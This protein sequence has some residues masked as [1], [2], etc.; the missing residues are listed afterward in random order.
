M[1]GSAKTSTSTSGVTIPPEVLARY[2]SVNATAQNVAQTPFQQYSTNPNAF[3]APLTPTQN[4]GVANTNAAVGMAQ[5]YYNAATGFALAGS[6]PVN[7][8]PLDTGQYMNPYLN[9]VLGSTAAQIN[10]N[11]QQAQSG[12]T[13]TAMSQGYFGGD[14]SGIASAVLQG[15]QNL[16]AGQV[17]SGI[18]SDAY[19]QAMAAAQQ[20]QGV[21]LGAAQ[22]N[23]AATQQ[24]GETL[25]GLG[26][27]AQ[28]T[29]LA[30]AQAQ[31]GAGQVEQQTT[32]AGDT[33]LYN[34]FLQ[35]QS[36]PFQTAQFLANIAEGT[37]ALSGS[38]TTTQQPQSI[39]SDERLKEDMQPVGKGF[40]GANIYRFRYKG[41][42][43]TRLGFSAQETE[44]KH[45]EAV[46]EHGGFK[47]VDYGAAT[48][49]AARRGFALAANDNG[50]DDEE[51]RQ[52]R[53]AGGMSQW[54]SYPTGTNPMVIA[55][56]LAAQ[57][58]SYAPFSQAGL[59]GGQG[60]GGGPYGGVQGHVPA[61]SLPVGQLMV[62]HPVA[63]PQQGGLSDDLHSVASLADDAEGIKSDAHLAHQ[64]YDWLTHLGQPGGQGA[65]TGP[66]GEASGGLVEGDDMG[67]R[68]IAR[69]GR[70]P[71]GLTFYDPAHPSAA[72]AAELARERY[73]RSPQGIAANRAALAQQAAQQHAAALAAAKHP[74]QMGG[75]GVAPAPGNL[76]FGG[77]NPN[78][79]RWGT[80]GDLAHWAGQQNW[81]GPPGTV[82]DLGRRIFAAPLPGQS[83]PPATA[84]HAPLV[85]TPAPHAVA[86]PP[87]APPGAPRPVPAGSLHP[88]TPVHVAGPPLTMPAALP[89][90]IQGTRTPAV[91]INVG[92]VSHLQGGFAPANLQP[93]HE[94]IFHRV[95]DWLGGHFG[96]TG[97]REAYDARGIDPNLGSAQ[98]R[99][100]AGPDQGAAYDS[101][102]IDP[103][104]GSAQ[105]RA[106]AMAPPVQS[107]AFQTVQPLSQAVTHPDLAAAA[108]VPARD[109]R[110]VDLADAVPVDPQ[111]AARG[112]F[113]RARRR[114]RQ[115]GGDLSDPHNDDPYRPQGPG[116]N[117]PTSQTQTPK[118]AV[119][120]AP[121]QSGG[122]L[123]SALGDAASVASIA[124]FAL[125][126][127]GVPVKTG[128]RIGRDDGGLVPLVD[129]DAAS[130]KPG[131]HDPTATPVAAAAD[132]DTAPVPD[133]APAPAPKQPG[134]GAAAQPQ[135]GG[136]GGFLP[137]LFHGVEN[138]GKGLASA[139]GYQG[140]GHWDRDRLMPLLSAIG[141]AG[142]APTVHPFVALAAGLGGYGK[143]YMQQQQNEAQIGEEQANAGLTR[144]Q[145]LPTAL[146]QG[147][148]QQEG[149]AI[150]PRTNQIDWSRTITVPGKGYMHWGSAADLAKSVVGGGGGAAAPGLAT[151]QSQQGG[152]GGA[153]APAAAG[154]VRANYSGAKPSYVV[155]PSQAERNRA[156]QQYGIDPDGESYSNQIAAGFHS[157]PNEAQR[158]AATADAQAMQ[159]SPNAVATNQATLRDSLDQ[160]IK[161]PT[162]GPG[163][164]GPGQEARQNALQVYN[165]IAKVFGLPGDPNIDANSSE[166][167]ILNKLNTMS[168]DQLTQKYGLRAAST[169]AALTSALASG[170]IQKGAAFNI[171][172]QM[173][174]QN[175]QDR[176]FGE[177]RSNYQKLGVGDWQV[178]QAFQRDMGGLYDKERTVLPMMF[179][180]D[181]SGQSLYGRLRAHPDQIQKFEQGFDTTDAQGNTIHHAGFGPGFGRLFVEG[182]Q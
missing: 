83:A 167:E 118:L 149:P 81:A 132:D 115:D 7:A 59:Y 179:T 151:P 66:P 138:L 180:P 110:P 97:Q 116:L 63:A 79:G 8:A 148:V 68:H 17:Y 51:P 146:A 160:I 54:G 129:T 131:V 85:G 30:G 154:P 44:R 128:G 159:I 82:S 10:Q 20:Q 78:S 2:N 71:G 23:R 16:A 87:T 46:S 27:T 35:Q 130:A 94:D 127:F 142:S 112:G 124:K 29:A 105:S 12:Q 178:A 65:A 67:D 48:D 72:D 61:A 64:G 58:Q 22:A 136:G 137:S 139:A 34:Q 134:L 45:P 4:A 102:G 57:E 38:T 109:D 156:A 166:T 125:P 174:V 9:T 121:G 39:F 40:D 171:I 104:L 11:N 172:G 52:A 135:G 114:P 107:E 99:A 103:S 5:P 49:D 36:Y 126:F 3:V 162:T 32:Q 90:N 28:G 15:Q 76:N 75:T 13:G 152:V 95:G 150:D 25:A 53:Q 1:G 93:Y 92:D 140:D 106:F 155:G 74:Y 86:A 108:P 47:A 91:P 176:D 84:T 161:L 55:Q 96:S 119:A 56:L 113:A 77:G 169:A 62:A 164:V 88:H 21:N 24:T 163:A 158:A 153:G 143:A 60:A 173:M 18:A 14:R 144:Q 89:D 70:A 165:T 117:I 120:P 181:A 50:G 41:D 177:Y 80:A 122:G 33:A 141:A 69:A 182:D 6:Q 175:Q 170:H 100:F 111:L 26:T 123:G 31:L 73:N 168:G 145:T 19:N 43:T 42:P 37:G 98:S 147:M 157:G 101:S 133:P